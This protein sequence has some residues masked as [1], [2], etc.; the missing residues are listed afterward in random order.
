MCDG[1][2]RIIDTARFFFNKV[3][4]IGNHFSILYK[5]Y[6]FATYYH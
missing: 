3:R 6:I 4:K 5:K 1:L 2:C